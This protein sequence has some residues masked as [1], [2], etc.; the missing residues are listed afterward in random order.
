MPDT[1]TI[2]GIEVE[3]HEKVEEESK[4]QVFEL[5][6]KPTMFKK[7]GSTND[8]LLLKDKLEGGK[9]D[10]GSSEFSESEDKSRSRK[11]SMG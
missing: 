8:F 3:E 10:A 11:N 4:D 9:D 1:E 6:V 5:G 7:I 2:V